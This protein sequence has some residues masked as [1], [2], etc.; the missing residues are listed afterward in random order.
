MSDKTELPKEWHQEAKNVAEIAG[1]YLQGAKAMRDAMEKTLKD[2]IEA[3]ELLCKNTPDFFLDV[4]IQAS[5]IIKE[6]EQLL[7]ELQTL[8]PTQDGK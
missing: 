2:K 3:F 5:A 8:T 6:Y 7:T 1:N 4:K